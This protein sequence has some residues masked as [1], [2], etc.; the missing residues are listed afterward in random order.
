MTSQ[1]PGRGAPQYPGYGGPSAYP[2]AEAMH[3][4]GIPSEGEATASVSFKV[5]EE[6]GATSTSSTSSRSSSSTRSTTT[7]S[8]TQRTNSSVE[9]VTPTSEPTV[10]R[11]SEIYTTPTG[12]GVTEPRG[13]DRAPEMT[14][15]APGS[16]APA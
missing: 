7:R 5:V 11:A 16:R 10:P 3:K 4:K 12:T 2:Q 9:R 14:G 15:P 1:F 6:L 8:I 13:V